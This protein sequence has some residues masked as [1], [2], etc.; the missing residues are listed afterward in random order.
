MPLITLLTD[1]GTTDSYVAEVKASILRV[2][3]DATLVDI[4]HSVPPGDIR[5]AAY[6]LG[7]T[8]QLFPVGTVHLAVVDP[9]V[10]TER[11]ALAVTSRRPRVRRSR[12][13]HPD[14][15]A[16]ERRGRGRGAAGSLERG[17]D[18]SWARSLRPGRGGARVRD[19]RLRGWV[20]RFG[21]R[22]SC[23]PTPCR[24]TRGNRSSGRSCTWI[25]S[26]RSSPI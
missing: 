1:F 6:L 8:W 11:G 24:T 17:P 2:A 13:R 21:D 5:S 26:V 16:P 3:P 9:G 18:L 10:G 23:S 7:R 19:A 15:A 25:G 20:R 22:L 4:S 14:L 12:Q